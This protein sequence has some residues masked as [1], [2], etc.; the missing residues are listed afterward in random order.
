MLDKRVLKPILIIENQA[1]GKFQTL[2]NALSLIG[3]H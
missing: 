3:V 2:Q 1:L